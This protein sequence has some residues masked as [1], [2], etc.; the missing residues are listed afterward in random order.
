[1]TKKLIPLIID[2]DVGTDVD[3]ALAL[4]YA[5]K[6]PILDVKAISTVQGDTS[7]RAGIAKQI[8]NY[9][10][11]SGCIPKIFTGYSIEKTQSKYWIG[12]EG[13][14]YDLGKM[15]KFPKFPSF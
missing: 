8:C 2:T 12:F 7:I 9:C 3:D 15:K 6:S 1:M 13:K 10:R 4:A 11:E 14:G 5:L